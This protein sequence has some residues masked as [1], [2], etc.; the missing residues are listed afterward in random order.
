M[1][2]IYKDEVGIWT[3]AGGWI[4]RPLLPTKFKPGDKTESKHFSETVVAGIG[5]LEGRGK[6]SEY[7]MTC[8]IVG[9]DKDFP[10]RLLAS[11]NWY[12]AHCAMEVLMYN[13]PLDRPE[14]I[15]ILK[16][17]HQMLESCP[18]NPSFLKSKK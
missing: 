9:E 13:G 10:E 5:K 17:S 16:L 15:N 11:W 14:S 2:V 18:I 8:G 1:A 3:E 12:F 4:A 7:W 6:Y